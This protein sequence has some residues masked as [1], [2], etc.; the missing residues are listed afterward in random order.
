MAKLE[1]LFDDYAHHH[2]T[3]GNKA[4]HRIGIPLI[5]LSLLGMLARVE[6]VAVNSFRID[7]AVILIFAASVYYVMLDWKLGLAMLG[8]TII[9]YIA[10]AALP[11]TINIILFILGWIFQFVG[12]SVYEKKQPA[13]LRNLVHLLVGPLW[14]LRGVVRRH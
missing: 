10:G 6:V 9:L 14:I 7:L 12:H 5:V 8:A 4:M 13:F 3:S 2:Q 1:A 11:L